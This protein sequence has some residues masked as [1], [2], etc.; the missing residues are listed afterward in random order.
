VPRVPVNCTRCTARA[1]RLHR[2]FI[3][4]IKLGKPEFFFLDAGGD[5]FCG[6]YGKNAS[7]KTPVATGR[8]L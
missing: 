6:D 2:F 8:D 1:G 7:E 5:H 4:R 3:R